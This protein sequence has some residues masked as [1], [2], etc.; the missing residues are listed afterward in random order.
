MGGA[1][2]LVGSSLIGLAALAGAAAAQAQ[3]PDGTPPP[4]G[5]A[6]APAP[7]PNSIAVLYFDNLSSDSSDTF[8]AQGITEELIA[9]L[10]EVEGL[11]VK[12]RFSVLRYRD[13]KN[14]DPAAVGRALRVA[15]LVTGSLQRAGARLRLRAELA[16]ASTGDRLW[17]GQY[18]RDTGDAL[19][20]AEDI[21]RE[22]VSAISQKLVPV[23]RAS[24]IAPGAAGRP[25]SRTP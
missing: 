5:P 22:I 14:P 20:V 13:D 15:Y 24:E 25:A 19:A 21:A 1:R 16:R 10:G 23:K 17:G 18:E 11:A 7:A 2:Q 12:S 9:R 4:C 6:R 3:C 8:L